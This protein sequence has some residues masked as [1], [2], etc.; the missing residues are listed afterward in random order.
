MGYDPSHSLIMQ[1]NVWEGFVHYAKT[2]GMDTTEKNG[3]LPADG[4]PADDPT[5]RGGGADALS[6]GL[7]R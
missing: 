3:Q 4:L 6:G 2:P 7:Y 5:G 1:E